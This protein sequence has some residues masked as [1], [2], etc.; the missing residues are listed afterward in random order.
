MICVITLMDRIKNHKKEVS[1]R[2]AHDFMGDAAIPQYMVK[3]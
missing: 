1:L 3:Q 2:G